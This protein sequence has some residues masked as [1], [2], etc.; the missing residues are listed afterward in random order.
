MVDL[1]PWIVNLPSL[2]IVNLAKVQ[3]FKGKWPMNFVLVLKNLKGKSL[4]WTL[5][6]KAE[7]NVFIKVNFEVVWEFKEVVPKKKPNML[8]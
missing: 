5:P 7:K 4:F 2:V 1:D 8:L 3:D 6:T